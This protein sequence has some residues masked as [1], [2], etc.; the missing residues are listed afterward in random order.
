MGAETRAAVVTGGGRG[1]GRG[2]ALKLAE[3]GF[4]LVINYRSDQQAATETCREAE[5]RGS[6]RASC[7]QA[8]VAHLNDG[9]RLVDDAVNAMGQVDLWVN[10]AGVAPAQRSD[11]LE[12]TAESWDGVVDTNLRGTFFLTQSVSKAMIELIAAG[13]VVEPQIVFITSISSVFASVSRAEYCVAKAGLSMVAQLFAVRLADAGIRVYEIRPGL[14]ATSMTQPVRETYDHKIAAGV[15][16]IRRWGTP[17]DVGRAVA[18]IATGAFPYST[19][20][21]FDVDGGLHLRVL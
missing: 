20:A 2:I 18:A 7:V 21:I 10:N 17:D 6:P 14:I 15:T 11:L 5:L 12:T 4:A 16:P 19:G 3:Q 9:R 8:D 13:S 1:I